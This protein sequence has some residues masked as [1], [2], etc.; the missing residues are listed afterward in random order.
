MYHP[1]RTLGVVL[2][3]GAY[4]PPALFDLD[5]AN[6]NSKK[7]LGYETFGHWEFFQANDAAKIIENNLESFTDIVFAND[8]T[9]WRTNFVLVGKVRDWLI[10]KN[11][12]IRASYITEEDYKTLK[13][14]FSEG[15]QPKLNW[16]KTIIE[17]NDWNN[18]KDL[19]PFVK[20]SD[21][22]LN[23][24]KNLFYSS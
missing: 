13:Q 4:N 6:E 14:Y 5:R 3:S 20:R 2:I 1:E 18:E 7:A 8:P 22:H 16:F 21:F 15:M 10:N 19:D 12:T 11:R 17:N 9:L 24:I 23:L